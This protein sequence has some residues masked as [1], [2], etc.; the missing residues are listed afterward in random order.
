MMNSSI[1][2]ILRLA[3]ACLVWL[4]MPSLMAQNVEVWMTKGD[5]SVLLQ[6]QGAVAFGTTSGNNQNTITLNES[7]TYQSIEGF[8]FALTQGSAEALSQLNSSEQDALLQ[9]L[10][11][12]TSGNGISIIRISIGASDLSNSVYTYN[13]TAGDV[14]MTNFSLAGP[15]QTYLIP[16]IKKILAINPSIKILATPWTAPTWMKS[17]GGWIGGSLNPTYYAA[18][19]NYFV[20]YFNAM[21]AQG[22]SIWGITPQNEPENGNNE[23]SMLMN[24]TEQKNFINNHLGPAL[25]SAGYTAKIIAFDH[26]C[27]N[28]SYPIDVLNNSSYVD[29]AAFHLYA[30]NISAMSTVKNQTGKNVYFTEQFT[31]V[32]G[33]FSGD[34]NWH[35]ENVV[36]GS[37]RN[38]SK[39]V[40]EWNLASNG[41]HGPRT[42]GGCSDCLGAITVN[43][44]NAFQRNVSYYIVSQISKFVQ[45]GAVRF[46]S[47]D[48]NAIK[49]VAFINPDGSKVLLAF[50]T[51][52][53]SKVIR[54]SGA[55]GAF[56]FNLDAKTAV[57]FRWG[58]GSVSIPSAPTGLNANTSSSNSVSLSWNSSSG[59]SSYNVK[60]STTSGGSY[61]IVANGISTT[62]YD[63]GGLTS[64][65]TYYYVVS[66][67]N[68]AGESS[69][70]SE[71]NATP[72]QPMST[73]SITSGHIYKITSKVSGKAIDV[74]DVSLNNG[75]R[76]QQWEYSGG[77]N[78]KWLV[79][80]IGGGLYTLKA[81][82]SGKALDV[83]DGSSRNGTQI[84]QWDY[85][86][87]A[88]QKWQIA[89][90]G[91]GYFK[92]IAS[93][94]GKALDLPNGDTSNGVLLQQWRL[95]N[96]DNQLFAFEDLDSGSRT[97][98]YE[99]KK[100][101]YR[102]DLR[103]YP[104]PVTNGEFTL[105]LND[106]INFPVEVELTDL[107]GKT[108]G[109]WQS[110]SPKTKI[111]LPSALERGVYLLK[112]RNE[113]IANVSKIF[114]R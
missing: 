96:N 99:D 72:Q 47:T 82:H 15:D 68:S 60:R 5:Q 24:A 56:D 79:E 6:Q 108:I 26:N 89:D 7:N 27:D 97:A 102:V 49:N 62:S 87:N 20:S 44:S 11:N 63:D 17:N 94:S 30:G 110:T 39:T 18:Y 107:S 14:N 52:N 71:V 69:H 95:G 10:F 13:E 101:P 61:N 45:P 23:P 58:T 76:I 35:M 8:G 53:T 86:N 103:I 33:Q 22:I 50:N 25:T 9:E 98:L 73:G 54:V 85:S 3:L 67:V 70:S 74:R 42:P 55:S 36:V 1:N 78:Q 28:T 88:N 91:N 4:V 37:L 81:V 77:D 32:N 109:T 104:N 2:K 92:L 12:P 75:A 65:Q 90:Q 51:N 105:E 112:V 29:G 19:A 66:A 21:A 113:T 80:D 31:G 84:Q 16:M 46:E 43:S 48:L 114:I 64:G 59:A 40:I 111:I 38:W 83:V 41:N 57:T 106:N 93:H 100:A 34:L